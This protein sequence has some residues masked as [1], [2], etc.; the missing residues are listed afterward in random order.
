MTYHV[1]FTIP[2][3]VGTYAFILVLPDVARQWSILPL[4]ERRRCLL[5]AR[6]FCPCVKVGQ[7]A[8]P[9][10]LL[11]TILRRSTCLSA[12]LLFGLLSRLKDEV[13]GPSQALPGVKGNYVLNLYPFKRRSVCPVHTNTLGAFEPQ[14][15]THLP[16][17][18]KM[19][20]W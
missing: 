10:A 16:Q 3:M 20:L 14:L 17:N 9:I 18:G 12:A 6:A 2:Y 5:V 7:S 15:W 1:P 4:N 13:V 11:L 19:G 8:S